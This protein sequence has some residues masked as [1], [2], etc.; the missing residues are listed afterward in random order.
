MEFSAAI[1]KDAPIAGFFNS[2][3][4][5]NAMDN[6]CN[7]SRNFHAA[8]QKG[9]ATTAD[10]AAALSNVYMSVLSIVNEGADWVVTVNDIV[11]GEADFYSILNM[12]P[13]VSK[14]TIR[15]VD[16]NGKVLRKVTT[17]YAGATFT[18]STTHL[19]KIKQGNPVSVKTLKIN[20]GKAGLPVHDYEIVHVA[21]MTDPFGRPV[22]GRMGVDGAGNVICGQSGKP[23]IEITD[24]GLQSMEQAAFTVFHE[25]HHIRSAIGS[26]V[27][28]LEQHANAYAAKMLER[29]RSAQRAGK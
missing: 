28:S 6:S 3:G 13:L 10:Y 17:E 18:N 26:G 22:F 24:L 20:L 27:V 14:G 9:F 25:I 2:S 29:L 11:Q 21:N 12:L 8:M 4:I 16:S 7:A 19:P 23:L 15:L 5:A 1:R